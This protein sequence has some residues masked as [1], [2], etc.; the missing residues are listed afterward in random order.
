MSLVQVNYQRANRLKTKL[1]F[2]L[3][4]LKDFYERSAE[5]IW[6]ELTKDEN[7]FRNQQK[8]FNMNPEP[9]RNVKFSSLNWQR[10][11]EC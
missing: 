6:S 3:I 8:S 11:F 2:F 9:S 5:E 1:K 4:I 7:I 10:W